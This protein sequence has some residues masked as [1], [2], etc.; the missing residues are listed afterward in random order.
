MAA[1]HPDRSEVVDISPNAKDIIKVLLI[2]IMFVVS[3]IMVHLYVTHQEKLTS[4]ALFLV[5]FGLIH[6]ICSTTISYLYNLNPI[7]P[8]VSPKFNKIVGFVSIVVGFVL[9]ISIFCLK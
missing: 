1:L 3:N 9:I 4:F 8:S 6:C 2:V 7:G 5:A